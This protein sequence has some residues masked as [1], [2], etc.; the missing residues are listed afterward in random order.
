M[1]KKRYI[2]EIVRRLTQIYEQIKTGHPADSVNL[3][4]VEGFMNAGVFMGLISN[5]DLNNL[6]EQVHQNVFGISVSERRRQNRYQWPQE[7]TDYSGYES[8]TYERGYRRRFDN[9]GVV[10]SNGK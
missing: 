10:F 4:R 5:Y 2:N 3:H 7:T 8:P 1:N 6:I 9:T